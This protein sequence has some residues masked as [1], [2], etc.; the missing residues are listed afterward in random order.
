MPHDHSEFELQVL[1][2]VEAA[3]ARIRSAPNPLA[4]LSRAEI[5]ASRASAT[6]EVLGIGPRRA[7]HG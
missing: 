7:R 3:R 2:D 1:A 4:G 5:R 6:P